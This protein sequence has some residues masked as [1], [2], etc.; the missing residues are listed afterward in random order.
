MVQFMKKKEGS[1]GVSP[2]VLGWEILIDRK[3]GKTRSF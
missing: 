1:F 3:D 2:F